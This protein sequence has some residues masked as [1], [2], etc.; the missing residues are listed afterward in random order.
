MAGAAMNRFILGLSLIAWPVLAAA[1]DKPVIAPT[2]SWVQQLAMP[3][4]AGAATQAGVRVLLRDQQYNFSPDG[5]EAYY[6]KIVLVQTPEGLGTVGNISL[7][8]NPDSE[9]LTVH[10]LR[11]LRG[12]KIIDVLGS[13]QDFTVLRREN[14]LEEAMLDGVLTAAIQ[15]AGMQ[16]GD[17][18]DLAYTV[19]RREPVLGGVSE[20]LAEWP[21]MPM[22]HFHLHARWPKSMAMRWRPTLPL[23]GIAIVSSGDFTEINLAMDDVEPAILPDDAPP[24]FGDGQQ[25]DF[26]AFG[27]WAELAGRFAPLYEKASALA[28][29][30]PLQAE[31]ARIAAASADPGTRAAAALRLVQDQVRYVF[32]GM[33]NGGLVP[34]N[35]DL[36]WSRRFGDCKGKTALLLALLHGL[37]I[38]AEPVLVSSDDGDGL[39]SRLPMAGRFDHVLVRATVDGGTYWLDGTREG[40]RRLADL[41]V[42]AYYW[43]LPLRRQSAALLPMTPTAP[44]SPTSSTVISIDARAGL[45]VPAP[46]RVETVLRGDTAVGVKL[47]FAEKS[48]GELDYALRDYWQRRY[49]FVKIQTVDAVYDDSAG[50]ERLMMSGTADM[51]WGGGRYEADDM[52]L[53]WDAHFDRAP[54]PYHDAPFAVQFPRYTKYTETILLPYKGAQFSVD[55]D[56]IDRN[57]AGV[58]YRRWAR[59]GN[60]A[61]MA[62]ATIRSLM[63]EF[64][65]ADAKQAQSALRDMRKQSVYLREPSN[66]VLTA[67]EVAAELARKLTTDAEFAARGNM[68]LN[69]GDYA[70]AIADTSAAIALNPKNDLALADRGLAYACTGRAA[71][72]QKDLDAAFVINAKNAVL[73]RGKGVLAMKGGHYADAVAA[74]TVSLQL[75]PDNDFALGERAKAY[76]LAGDDDDALADYT[77]YQAR[78]PSQTISYITLANIYHHK[79]LPDQA[80]AQ[81][82]AMVAANPDNAE[83]FGLAGL[84]YAS[85][86]KDADAAKAFDRSIE[87]DASAKNYLRR[88]SHRAATDR[89]GRNADIVAALQADP[90]SVEA[91]EMRARAQIDDAAYTDAIATL[92]RARTIA[93]DTF[94]VLVLRGWAYAKAQK[95][96][97]AEKDF[98][99]ARGKAASAND[100]NT[101]CWN[102]AVTGVA[103]ATA[104]DACDA[105]LAKA[106]S[107]ANYLDSRGMVLL[108][109]NRYDDAIRAYTAALLVRP[110]AAYSLYGRA[111]AER[112][113][114]DTEAAEADMQAAAQSDARIADTFAEYGIK[115]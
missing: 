71:E 93:G 45:H 19:R 5:D 43:G 63:P 69:R 54:G 16:V 110:N 111:I 87:L 101:L 14:N 33:K 53:G 41:A 95:I 92:D 77:Q 65:A 96:P 98:A 88:A 78:L 1:A 76:R 11:L 84:I 38:E 62:E 20:W 64:S 26:S 74:F 22:A 60:G 4:V 80:I 90:R 36:T 47:R 58:H 94:D 91:L 89:G 46:M 7:P 40:D 44:T 106:P 105:A 29:G 30:S 97:K 75:E 70:H 6:E 55:G 50:E 57:A 17:I 85:L 66:Y 32:L 56:D 82:Q 42:P 37:G 73:F 99:A 18:V 59:I 52:G 83:A 114:G 21:N 13:G 109:L 86:N 112:R 100:L 113:R 61:F 81:A 39:D 28:A 48:R 51:D 3:A 2:P 49:D 23:P 103:L 15:P 25:L 24:R 27:S 107:V 12:G 108:R 34:A 9:T 67:A 102:Q 115:P 35:A 68:L 10:K 72:A 31:I 8:W 104:L 79:N